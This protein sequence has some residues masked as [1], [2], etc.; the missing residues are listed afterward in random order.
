MM[1]LA[2]VGTISFASAD[3]ESLRGGAIE[4]RR[5]SIV[6]FVDTEEGTENFDGIGD[7][8]S[9]LTDETENVNILSDE[10]TA[11]TTTTA[12]AT[13]SNCY[14]CLDLS[15]HSGTG[16]HSDWSKAICDREVESSP[17][18]YQW[19]D[20]VA[21]CTWENPSSTYK[22][23]D[24]FTVSENWKDCRNSDSL[25]VLGYDES[26]QGIDTGTVAVCTV[27]NPR[28]EYIKWNTGSAWARTGFNLYGLEEGD[29]IAIKVDKA[30]KN[31]FWGTQLTT[32][33]YWQLKKRAIGQHCLQGGVCVSGYCDPINMKCM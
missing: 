22:S 26:A 19:C 23:Q 17:S 20:S 6:N 1:V 31:C 11:T 5:A 21:E 29:K 7:V 3:Q 24:Y 30:G 28:Y 4:E 2:G 16:C 13:C 18:R 9:D 33:V 14:G 10:E 8:L 12:A 27:I 32:R 25:S 15:A